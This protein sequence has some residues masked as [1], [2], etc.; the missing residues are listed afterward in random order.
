MIFVTAGTHEQPFDRVIKE[1]DRLTGAEVIKE[2][3]FIQRGIGSMVPINCPSAEVIS[4]DDMFKKVAEARIVI[5]HGGPGSIMLPLSMGKIPIVIPRRAEFNEHVDNHQ[6]DF[7][8]RLEAGKKIIA[9]YKINELEAGI[10]NYDNLASALD[11]GTSGSDEL[12]RLVENLN[13]YCESLT[14]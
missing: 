5:T 1:V 7:A 11:A 10:L 14:K 3:V 6:V 13:R 8:K 4:Y 2:E 9:I 12:K